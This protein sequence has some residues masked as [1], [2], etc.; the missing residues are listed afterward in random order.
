LG[1]F[2]FMANVCVTMTVSGITEAEAHN[3]LPDLRDEFQHRSWIIMPTA[4][5]DVGRKLIAI[6]VGYGSGD[7]DACKQAA[8]SE[9]WDCVIACIQF[10][11][12]KI[13]FEIE[14]ACYA[15]IA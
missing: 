7:I 10:S 6:T 15:P 1:G 13:S 8:Q 2:A 9:I 11:S 4:K 12:D 14:D 5:W 3:G